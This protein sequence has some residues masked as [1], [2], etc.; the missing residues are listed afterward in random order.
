[1]ADGFN[2]AISEYAASAHGNVKPTLQIAGSATQLDG[3]VALAI[4]KASGLAK[5]GPATG[6]RAPEPSTHT[7]PSS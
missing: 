4:T 6:A 5:A 2:N 3:P 1:M 7:T